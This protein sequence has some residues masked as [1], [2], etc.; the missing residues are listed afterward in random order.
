MS[1]AIQQKHVSF[2]HLN[3]ERARSLHVEERRTGGGTS[4]TMHHIKMTGNKPELLRR[5]KDHMQLKS[6]ACNQ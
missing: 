5:V 2:E 6:N 4:A 3:M 1:L